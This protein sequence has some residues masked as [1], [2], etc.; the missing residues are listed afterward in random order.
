MKITVEWSEAE[1]IA[2]IFHEDVRIATMEDIAE[3]KGQVFPPLV[4]IAMRTGKKPLVVVCI[5]GVSID[6]AVA[7]EY[8]KGAKYIAEQLSAGLARYGSAARVRSLI[9]KEAIKKGYKANLFETRDEA[10][11]HVL[12][13]A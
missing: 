3:W 13:R 8:G 1:H 7:D 4:E 9:A 5:D 10:R 11:R 12:V 2:T 6:P